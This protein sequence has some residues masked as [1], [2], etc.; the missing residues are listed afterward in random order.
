MQNMSG[1]KKA[2]GDVLT[3]QNKQYFIYVD[4]KESHNFVSIYDRGSTFSKLSDIQYYNH[5]Q[6]RQEIR[7][8]Q[9]INEFECHLLSHIQSCIITTKQKKFAMITNHNIHILTTLWNQL[10]SKISKKLLYKHK[11]VYLGLT[12]LGTNTKIPN[13]EPPEH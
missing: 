9:S 12:S 4:L 10:L 13:L 6:Y 7:P 1:P 2:R 8:N 11:Q 3:F 5:I